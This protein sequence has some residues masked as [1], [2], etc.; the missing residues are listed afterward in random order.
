MEVERFIVVS[1][2]LKTGRLF[3]LYTKQVFE[4]DKLRAP[5]R[6]GVV[7]VSSSFRTIQFC[8]LFPVVEQ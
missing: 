7:T 5:C 4:N 2:S 8:I 6:V 3:A 1:I